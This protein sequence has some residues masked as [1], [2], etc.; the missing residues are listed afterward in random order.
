MLRRLPCINCA[1]GVRHLSSARVPTR[2]LIFQSGV[3]SPGRLSTPAQSR[4]DCVLETLPRGL[5]CCAQC[6]ADAGPTDAPRPGRS[7]PT[8]QLLL[9]LSADSCYLREVLKNFLVA[10]LLPR[11]SQRR[12]C[13]ACRRVQ[14]SAGGVDAVFADG[15][16][17]AGHEPAAGCLGLAAERA[18][19]PVCFSHGISIFVVADSLTV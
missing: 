18:K 7:H 2:F 5:P 1:K 3:S 10:Q 4:S 17:G 19:L 11:G 15:D 16:A 13:R 14:E 8:P 9:Q 6:G 12:R